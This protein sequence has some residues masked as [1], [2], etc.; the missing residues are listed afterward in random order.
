MIAGTTILFVSVGY[1]LFLRAVESPGVEPLPERLADLPLTEQVRGAPAVVEVNRMHGKEFP[2]TSGAV[3][4][5]GDGRQATIWVSGEPVGLMANRILI[6]MRDKI[7]EGNS[8]F[9]SLG[10]RK[11]GGRSVYELE[12]L[13]QKHYYFQS[14][15]LVIW[16]AAD[17]NLAEQALGQSLEFYP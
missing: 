9:T 13:D 6:A 5:Y 2:L 3:G 14:A 16:L 12:G 7:A 17:A 8:P 4:I 11:V 15:N 10:E 1:L